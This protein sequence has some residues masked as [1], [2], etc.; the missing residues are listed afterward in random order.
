MELPISPIPSENKP[1][2]KRLKSL[3][4][5]LPKLPANFMILGRCGSGKSSCLASLLTKGYMVKGKSV[6]DEIVVFLGSQDSISFFEKLPSKNV[7]VLQEFDP[8]AFESYLDDLKTHQMERLN[9][10]K[11]PLNVA[12][13]FDD[14]VGQNLMK[15]SNGKA[16]PLERLALTSRHEANATLFFLSQVYKNTGFSQPSIR[17]NITTY[18][19]YQMTKPEIQKIAEEHCN[20]LTPEEFIEEYDKIMKTPHN[21][22]VIDYRRPLN[23]RI[24]ERFTKPVKKSLEIDRDE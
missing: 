14:F 2:D 18:I 15:H 16:S 21:F 20:E 23:Q 4:Y 13:I 9:K 24:T 12:I 22:M 7:V 5:E 11:P 17:N 3:Q 6:F 8:D 10:N 1:I 19:I